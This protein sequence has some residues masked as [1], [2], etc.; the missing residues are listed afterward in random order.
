MR[1]LLNGLN[2]QF[3]APGKGND[4]IRTPEALP[5]GRNFYALDG[6]LLPTRVG[7]EVG[8][9]LA[10]KVLA[11]ES[12]VALANTDIA[13]NKQGIILWASDAVRDEVLAELASNPARH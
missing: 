9:A 10:A 5:T 6:S 7:V 3:V 4:P 8:T 1:A 2:G 12:G 13:N 11:G